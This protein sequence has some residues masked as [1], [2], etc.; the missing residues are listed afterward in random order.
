MAWDSAGPLNHLNTLLAGI[1]GVGQTTKGI[2]ESVG[3][4]VSASVSVG[5]QRLEFDAFKILERMA[6]YFVEFAYRVQG[7]EGA[8]EDQLAT[9]LDA[10]LTAL[11]ADQTL[12]GTCE[13]IETDFS[14]TSDPQYRPTAGQEFRTFSFVV[15][16][17]QTNA[18]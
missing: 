17:R 15:W 16:A 11:Y 1:A 9:F 6:G 5:G 4:R 18:A 13:W 8:A 12:G 10:F 14:L 3:A 2:P 7:N